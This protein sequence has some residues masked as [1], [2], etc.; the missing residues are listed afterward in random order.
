LFQTKVNVSSKDVNVMSYVDI[1]YIESRKM[2]DQYSPYI[3]SRDLIDQYSPVGPLPNPQLLSPDLASPDEQ[4]FWDRGGS[5][6]AVAG[7]S[8][9]NMYTNNGPPMLERA[10]FASHYSIDGALFLKTCGY[11][12]VYPLSPPLID[13]TNYRH[14]SQ[15]NQRNPVQGAH[16]HSCRVG[17]HQHNIGTFKEY[18]KI[19]DVIDEGLMYKS[20]SDDTLSFTSSSHRGRARVGHKVPDQVWDRDSELANIKDRY[21]KNKSVHQKDDEIVNHRPRLE[22]GKSKYPVECKHVLSSGT[23]TNDNTREDAKL[24]TRYACK[25]KTE[26]MEQDQRSIAYDPFV[27]NKRFNSSRM[28]H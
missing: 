8:G 21:S 14:T 12:A 23:L 28:M 9:W 16:Q 1:P 25:S 6:A 15:T 26:N 7:Q 11:A 3:D 10:D 17:A 27:S 18:N 2:I 5:M 22:R 20:R 13:E 4:C 24:G 19:S